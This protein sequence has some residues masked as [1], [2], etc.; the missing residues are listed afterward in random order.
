MDGFLV[1]VFR[2][3]ARLLLCKCNS[4][5]VE[6]LLLSSKVLILLGSVHLVVFEGG[7]ESVIVCIPAQKK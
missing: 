7:R 6:Y 1:L 2:S 4:M 3:K 5:L